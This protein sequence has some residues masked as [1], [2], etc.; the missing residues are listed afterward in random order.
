MSDGRLA[1]G[2]SFLKIGSLYLRIGPAGAAPPV[3]SG[4]GFSSNFEDNTQTVISTAFFDTYPVPDRIIAIVFYVDG[5][6]TDI[7]SVSS[8]TLGAWNLISTDSF[9]PVSPIQPSFAGMSVRA[10]LFDVDSSSLTTDEAITAD[11][12]ASKAQ[13]YMRYCYLYG[14]T[15]SV[16]DDLITG[17]SPLSLTLPGAGAVNDIAIFLAG[18]AADTV[19]LGPSI[20]PAGYTSI[21]GQQSEVLRTEIFWTVLTTT[22]PP[23]ADLDFTASTAGG[24]FFGIEY[25]V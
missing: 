22:D 10:A 18:G 11:A 7:P 4:G 14:V 9:G 2:S 25:G 24:V 1:I 20:P 13:L 16:Q 17:Q 12:G 21:G 23:S 6:V 8:A 3:V 5:D 19:L 15:G